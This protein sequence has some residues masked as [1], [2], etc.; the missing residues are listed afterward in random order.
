MKF[1][2]FVQSLVNGV[3]LLMLYSFLGAG[4]IVVRLVKVVNG[5]MVV[6]AIYFQRFF[7]LESLFGFVSD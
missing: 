2:I 7:L 6:E 3:G 5:F 4:F 1:L